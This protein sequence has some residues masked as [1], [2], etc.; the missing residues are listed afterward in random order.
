MDPTDGRV[1]SNFIVLALHGAPLEY[2]PN[3]LWLA[4][5]NEEK[6]A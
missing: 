1:V 3:E 2:F 5:P 6:A 4:P